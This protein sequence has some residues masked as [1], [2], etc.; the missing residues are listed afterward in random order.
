MAL[1]Y[2]ARIGPRNFG[3]LFTLL[4]ERVIALGYRVAHADQHPCPAAL[5]PADVVE[6]VVLHP[7]PDPTH[8]AHPLDQRFGQVT[9]DLVRRDRQPLLLRL[10]AAPLPETCGFS[11][12]PPFDE[13]LRRVLGCDAQ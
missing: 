3:Y 13:L 11:K 8:G 7:L 12:A 2:D 5:H 10:L 1:L 6:K 4:R 9:V